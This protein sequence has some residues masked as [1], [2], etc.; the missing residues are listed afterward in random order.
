MN[1][2]RYYIKNYL[3]Y[4]PKLFYF[5]RYLNRLI[6]SLTNLFFPP[7]IFQ[8]ERLLFKKIY[9]YCKTVFDVGA[10]FD[11]DYIEISKG[12]NIEYHLFEINPVFFEKLQKKLSLFNNTEKIIV[13]NVGIGD[14]AGFLDYCEKTQS[15]F[16]KSGVSKNVIKLPVITLHSYLKKKIIKRID[17]LK[18]D[19]EYYDYFALLSLKNYLK[20]IKFIQFELGLGAKLNVGDRKK[21]LQFVGIKHYLNL[22]KKDFVLYI[23]QDENNPIWQKSNLKNKDLL[24]FNE[25]DIHNIIKFTKVGIGFNIFA[26]SK[27]INIS[28]LGLSISRDKVPDFNKFKYLN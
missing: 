26:I 6:I 14:R 9:P 8:S 20:K 10:R 18:T 25:K 19:I 22:L 15:L 23:L 3:R 12:N 21:H 17:F 11:V 5:F 16:K 24:L 1:F 7:R 2:L 13:N 4:Y 28:I 27:K